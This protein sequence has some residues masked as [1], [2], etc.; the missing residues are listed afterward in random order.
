MVRVEKDVNFD[1][2]PGQPTKTKIYSVRWTGFLTP[3]ES[4]N[5][6]LGL[7]GCLDRLWLDGKMIV[8][9]RKSHDS[10]A[11]GCRSSAGEGPPLRAEN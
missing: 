1:F 7:D 4:G 2:A 9:D 11:G 8:E 6:R 3:A 5:Y 10:Q